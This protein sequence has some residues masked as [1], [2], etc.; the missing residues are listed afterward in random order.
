MNSLAWHPKRYLLLSASQD[1]TVLLWERRRVT[2]E[3]SA[4]KTAQPQHSYQTPLLRGLLFG[5]MT[6]NTPSPQR[7]YSWHCRSKFEPKSEAVR[8]IRWSP[9][10]EDGTFLKILNKVL[11]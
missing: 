2:S 6:P 4:A 10:Y 9:F 8:D 1:A 11:R 5:G 7:S 3:E